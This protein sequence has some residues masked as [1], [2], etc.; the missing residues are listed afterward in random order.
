MLLAYLLSTIDSK[1]KEGQKVAVE[2]GYWLLYRFNPRLAA[3]GKNPF[4]LG[5]KDPMG[6]FQEF[7]M[8]A[9]SY[10]LELVA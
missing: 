3:E 4:Q 10:W 9:R 6:E 2:A 8:D 5:M 7:L 1:S